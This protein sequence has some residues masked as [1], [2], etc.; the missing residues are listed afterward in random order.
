M[1]F[2]LNPFQL[3][4][5]RKDQ[6]EIL[7]IN[8]E[9]ELHMIRSLLDTAFKKPDEVVPIL[10]DQGSGKSSTLTFVYRLAKE[11]GY[12]VASYTTE[13]DYL[14]TDLYKDDEVIILDDLDKADDDTNLKFYK[15][16]ERLIVQTKF[17]FFTDGYKRDD[18]VLQERQSVISQKV[19]LTRFDNEKLTNVLEKRMKNCLIDDQDF[20]FPFTEGS[21]ELASQRASNNLRAFI[22]YSKN[23]WTITE[24]QD[25]ITKEDMKES[26]IMED[27]T[28][29]KSLSDDEL[30]VIWYGTIG[31][32]N[33]GYMSNI[34]DI[35]RPTLTKRIEKSN[36]L[37]KER[38]GMETI[39]KSRYRNLDGGKEILEKML[40]DLGLDLD[41][42]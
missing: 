11:K 2:E 5:V 7:Y 31:E 36:L 18:D 12:S 3:Y 22:K 27:K 15:K 10:G 38:S 34:C 13:D 33:L 23:A 42:I 20:R 17:I 35:S 30:K 21:M 41:K 1:K 32:F 4:P 39:V 28:Y 26:I 29:L 24:D 37:Y 16:I 19:P 6:L 14:S 8:R 40:D 25:N 9:K